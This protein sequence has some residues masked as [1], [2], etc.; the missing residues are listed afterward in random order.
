[1]MQLPAASMAEVIVTI[2]VLYMCVL[3]YIF[4]VDKSG[5]WTNVQCAPFLK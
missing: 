5:R 3:P 1:M 4:V 2:R